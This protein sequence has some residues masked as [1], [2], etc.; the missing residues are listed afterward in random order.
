VC[1]SFA[2][3]RYLLCGGDLF[4]IV[5]EMSTHRLLGQSELLVLL[6]VLRLGHEAYG[7]PISKEIAIRIGRDPAVAGIYARL[8]RLERRGLVST[9]AGEPTAV[10]G[11]RAKTYFKVTAKGLKELR[12]SQD[13]LQRFWSGIPQLEGVGS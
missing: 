1:Y 3:S 7:V 5:E 9:V 13:L 6:A 2:K 12:A 8:D 4:R 11:G 10:R